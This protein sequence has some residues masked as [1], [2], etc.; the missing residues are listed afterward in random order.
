MSIP[1]Q[2]LERMGM[3][4]LLC[5]AWQAIVADEVRQTERA[6]VTSQHFD[7]RDG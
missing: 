5:W 1:K 3:A 2:T 6:S 4:I 7:D